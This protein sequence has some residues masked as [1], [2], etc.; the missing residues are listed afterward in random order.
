MLDVDQDARGSV[1]KSLLILSFFPFLFI[2]DA[3]PRLY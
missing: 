1:G 2:W 3:K